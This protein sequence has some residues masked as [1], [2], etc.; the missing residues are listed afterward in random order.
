[1][2]GE[3]VAAEPADGVAGADRAAQPGGDLPQQLVAGRVAERVVDLLEAVEV[4]EED[5]E[6]GAV[7]PPSEMR[8][9]RA[10]RG[11]APGWAGR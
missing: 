6:V 4:A 7:A 2:I 11:R 10:A 9:R 5:A 8:A 1:M 3:L